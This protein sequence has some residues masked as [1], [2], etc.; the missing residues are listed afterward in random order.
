MMSVRKVALKQAPTL[1]E[2]PSM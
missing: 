1:G 2:W